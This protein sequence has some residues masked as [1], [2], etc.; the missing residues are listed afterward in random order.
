MKT[1][2]RLLRT[3]TEANGASLDLSSRTARVTIITEG[4]G[5]LKDRNYY[6][7]EAVRSAARV[8]EGKQCY[9][10]HPSRSEE[11]DRPERSVRDLCGYF[12]DCEVGSVRDPETGESLAACF[13]ELTFSESDPGNLAMAQVLA[14]LEYQKRYPRSKNVYCGLSING[15]GR[16]EAD[17]IG[18]MEVNRVDEITEAMSADVVTLP[19]RGGKFL[20]V[21]REACARYDEGE[22]R[23][24]ERYARHREARRRKE[25]AAVHAQPWGMKNLQRGYERDGHTKSCP[26][27]CTLKHGMG[28]HVHP[29]GDQERDVPVK[30]LKSDVRRKLALK[31]VMPDGDQQ[32][33]K[34]KPVRASIYRSAD[35]ASGEISDLLRD[36][37]DLIHREHADR[38]DSANEQ[39]KFAGKDVGMRK[40]SGLY[41]VVEAVNEIEREER[42]TDP[43]LAAQRVTREA[44][45][46]AGMYAHKDEGAGDP[47]MHFGKPEEPEHSKEETNYRYSADPERSCGRCVHFREPAGCELVDGLINE[48]DTCDLFAPRK[49]QPMSE[50]SR[51]REAIET[52]KRGYGSDSTPEELAV[53]ANL[54]R[55][56]R[57]ARTPRERK[58]AGK[59]YRK[60]KQAED[61]GMTR[62]RREDEVVRMPK[63][64]RSG[65]A[66]PR[67]MRRREDGG[68]FHQTKAPGPKP[69]FGESDAD[70]AVRTFK[71]GYG[72]PNESDFRD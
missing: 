53:A 23:W 30:S 17:T 28:N 58:E 60:A 2:L 54:G 18:G 32:D 31:R 56:L 25:Q 26:K 67:S 10:D 22:A 63:R 8:F 55:D 57:E 40:G 50:S 70:R 13:A 44:K 49:E 71:E 61:E 15:G 12:H 6:T 66:V 35:G 5:N 16:S 62:T 24:R 51:A 38:L 7:P 1:P 47:V 59:R 3:F 33:M 27:D 14:A 11:S 4:L 64:G 39:M 72:K 37:E 43:A 69:K 29:S 41:E 36:A 34:G 52:F 48:T 46:G 19:A 9:L 42:R 20:S 68:D 21:V 65:K 45:I